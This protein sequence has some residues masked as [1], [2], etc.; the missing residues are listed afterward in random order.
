MSK[1]GAC[2]LQDNN[3]EDLGSWFRNIQSKLKDISTSP[4]NYEAVLGAIQKHQVGSLTRVLLCH[5][6][7]CVCALYERLRTIPLPL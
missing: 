4:S 3:E 1:H 2:W 7:V 5:C 6:G